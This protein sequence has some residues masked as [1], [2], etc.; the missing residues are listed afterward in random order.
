MLGGAGFL[1]VG[2]PLLSLAGHDLSAAE[3]AAGTVVC[4]G[5]AMLPDLDH[6]QATC[7]QSLGPVT[8]VLARVTSK[9]FGGHR[10]GTHSLLFAALATVFFAFLLNISSGPWVALAICFF[11]SSLVVRTLTEASGAVSAAMSVFLAATLITVAP[12]QD[13]IFL[14]IGLGCLLHDLGDI[15]TPEGVP[16]LWPVS[17]VRVR[18]PVVGHTGD[19]REGLIAGL[20]GLAMCFLLATAVFLPTWK[21]SSASA[22]KR[23]QPSDSTELTGPMRKDKPGQIKVKKFSS[24]SW[25][26]LN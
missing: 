7:A 25:P 3:I 19:W 14:S 8:K 5:A 22:D 10:N 4:A 9:V 18:V 6:P 23:N 21:A 15:L 12:D 13:W 26:E 16:P 24:P 11:F 1:A 20:C 17:K 2:A